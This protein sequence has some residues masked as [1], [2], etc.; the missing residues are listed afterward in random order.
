MEIRGLERTTS[1]TTMSPY[2]AKNDSE[3]FDR[4]G[5]AAKRLLRQESW[6]ANKLVSTLHAFIKNSREIYLDLDLG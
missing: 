3:I 5:E 6:V 2:G 1:G 4:Q